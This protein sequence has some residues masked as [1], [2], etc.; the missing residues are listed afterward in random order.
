MVLLL[1]KKS[2]AQWRVVHYMYISS[3][4]HHGPDVVLNKPYPASLQNP[5]S[6]VNREQ[7]A[8]RLTGQRRL[9]DTSS[10]G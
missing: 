9:E 7:N 3:A 10:R 6:I 5:T 1:H 4:H 2:V 8:L